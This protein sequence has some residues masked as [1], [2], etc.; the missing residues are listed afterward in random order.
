[1]NARPK[2]F[3][4]GGVTRKTVRLPWPGVVGLAAVA[5]TVGYPLFMLLL[6]SVFP[7]L[8]HGS[9]RVHLAVAGR[10]PDYGTVSAT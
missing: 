10:G 9:L 3:M 5:L 1:M 7:Y 6:Q 4:V 8:A 2:S